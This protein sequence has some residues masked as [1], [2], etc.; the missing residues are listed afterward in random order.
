MTTRERIEEVLNKCL[1]YSRADQ[2]LAMVMANDTYLTRYATNYIHQNTAESNAVVHVTAVLGKKLGVATTN[3]LDDASLE[4]TVKQAEDI[5]RV[6]PDL[7]DFTSLPAEEAAGGEVGG[8]ALSPGTVSFDAESRARAVGR[9]TALAAKYGFEAAGAFA[10]GTMAV[11]VANS[12]GVRRYAEG[13]RASMTAVVMGPTGSGYAD[14]LSADATKIDVDRLAETAVGKCRD[15]QNPVAVEPGDYEVVLESAAVADMIQFLAYLGLGALAFQEGRSFMCGRLGQ[16]I[17]GD[18]ITIWDDGQD[19]AGLPLPF[20]FEGVRRQKVMLI[21]DGVAKGVVYDSYTA[22]REPGKASTGHALPPTIHRGPIPANL[23]MK[24]GSETMADMV[25]SMKRGLIV[26]RFHYTN[27]LHPVLTTITGMT[28][29]GTFLVEDGRIKGPVKNM[30]FTVNMLESLAE[31][32]GMSRERH[33]NDMFGLGAVLAPA[34]K[35]KKFTF[36]GATQF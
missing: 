33:L 2:T 16:K 5:A 19:P 35:L 21:E 31:T 23:F 6:Q 26:T 22:G 15:A 1:G 24:A 13:T 10:T 8:M 7:P 30:R 25:K 17:T 28:R 9:V 27:P 32:E 34:V 11:G 4:R 12:L 18:A 14:D 36:T 3:A 29:D 20:D